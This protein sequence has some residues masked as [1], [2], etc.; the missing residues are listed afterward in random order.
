MKLSKINLIIDAIMFIIMMV[1]VGIGFLIKYILVPGYTRNEIYGRD[2]DLSFWGLDRH[3]WGTIHLVLGFIL[4]FLLFLHIV[5]HWKVIKT[6][7]KQTVGN[8]GKRQVITW[9][10]V[11]VSLI[12]SLG[13]FFIHPKKHK[14][15]PFLQINN[16]PRKQA[17]STHKYQT[18]EYYSKESIG[19]AMEQKMKKPRPDTLKKRHK[20]RSINEDKKD[21]LEV[22]VQG[23]MSLDQL[24]HQYHIP[25]SELAR[26]FHINIDLSGE[27]LGRLKKHHDFRMRDIKDYIQQKQQIND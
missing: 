8:K 7:F 14:K 26:A 20:N 4:L 15:S 19:S 16:S 11:C 5:F 23:Y 27:R 17:V 18:A 10:F 9:A 13:F 2:I 6:L 24:A 25:V 22:K 3:Q 12:L 1:V 21:F